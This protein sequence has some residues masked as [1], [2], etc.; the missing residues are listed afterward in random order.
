MANFS[1][2]WRYQGGAPQA[3]SAV[4]GASVGADNSVFLAGSVYGFDGWDDHP[5][6]GLVDFAVAKL[7]ADGGF[8]WAW[9]EGSEGSDYLVSAAAV[10]DGGVVVA[11]WSNGTWNGVESIGD[12]DFA[13]IKLDSDG[14]VVWRWQN[15]TSEPDN[16]R[17]CVEATDGNVVMAG[18]TEGT[19][20]GV[21]NEGWNDVVAVK[22]DVETAE[23]IWTYQEGTSNN[24]GA[25]VYGAAARADGSVVL[26]G[27][28]FGS[29]VD[30]D[31]FYGNGESTDFLAIAIDED[32]NELWRWQ[33]GPG[34]GINVFVAAAIFDDDSVLLA[35]YTSGNWSGSHLGGYD[36]AAVKL[37]SSG[38]EEWR[39]QLG[40]DFDD[41]WE[42]AAVGID[43]SFVLS[44]NTYGSWI[45]SQA[46]TDQDRD[47]V[48]VSGD[49]EG[50]ILWEFQI[51]TMVEEDFEAATV[52]PDGLILLAGWTSGTFA[53][54]EEA[55]TL[56]DF[57][58]LLIDANATGNTSSTGTA[59]LSPSP[60]TALVEPTPSPITPI[61]A[62]TPSPTTTIIPPASSSSSS[63]LASP[64]VEATP[65]PVL[66]PVAT[67]GSEG[68]EL[69][70][71]VIV[72]FSAGVVF[73]AII[74]GVCLC[75]CL[76]RRVQEARSVSA[77]ASNFAGNMKQTANADQN[78]GG[79]NAL[80][81]PAY[82]EPPPYL[83]PP[84]Y[85]TIISANG[86]D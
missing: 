35:G 59:T 2:V 33:D 18:Y 30:S 75:C 28:T 60:T 69:S 63:F 6:S 77:A 81:P 44:G 56:Y 57:V 76:Q 39:L 50:N 71:E 25:Y 32:G 65:G 20:V 49:A 54:P 12:A 23:I 16:F 86:R 48:G 36:F 82:R 27:R 10:A 1:E 43:G 19:W 26:C 7:D 21:V 78:V 52:R 22:L 17:A 62:P 53:E 11:G 34:T 4:S 58:A 41:Q 80:P 45:G 9:L 15:G 3:S 66:T 38:E 8:L 70:I 46:G 79:A 51:G 47:F 61:V 37:D 29:F 73:L 84:S 14:D 68:L 67:S 5:S 42:G 74:I 31:S 83:K 40:T 64:I 55:D 72:G 24:A 85:S 13:A